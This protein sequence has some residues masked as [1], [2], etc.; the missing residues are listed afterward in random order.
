MDIWII[1]N[2]EKTGPLRDFEIRRKIEDGELTATVPAW[3]DGLPGWQP[4][5]EIDLFTR[6]FS[7]TPAP[8]E[9]LPIEPPPVPENSP[10]PAT[11]KLSQYGR[12]FLARWFDLHLFAGIWWLAMWASGRDIAATMMNPW[13]MILQF[14]PWFILEAFLLHRFGFTPGK[15]LLGLQVSNLDGSLMSLSESLRRA[16]RVLFTGIGF[17]WS[18]LAV[19]CQLLS[20][21]TAKRL[22]KPLWDH[23][24]H[25]Q[26]IR[27]PFQPLRIIG[28]AIIFAGALYLQAIVTSPYTFEYLAKEIPELEKFYGKGPP[29]WTL[30]KR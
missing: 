22:G 23:L 29:W 25:H 27:T 10:P 8:P 11:P 16:G 7:L 14:I 28:F 3:H 20:L 17:G 2:G 24:G 30:P 26:V 1:L 5:G 4:L 13:I 12:R 9:P 6:E 15:W 19:F 18:L 21:Y